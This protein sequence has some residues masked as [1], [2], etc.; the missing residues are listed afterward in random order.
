MALPA[1]ALKAVVTVGVS[2]D[3]SGVIGTIKNL[4]YNLMSAFLYG[5]R[6]VIR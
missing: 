3:I 4:E 5:P 6:L 2:S 1:D